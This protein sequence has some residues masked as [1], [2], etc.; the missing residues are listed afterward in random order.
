[1]KIVHTHLGGSVPPPLNDGS[2]DKVA[3]A[4]YLLAGDRVGSSH[5]NRLASKLLMRRTPSIDDFDIF[6]F[7]I[8]HDAFPPVRLS[9]TEDG[10]AR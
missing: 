7:N 10:S 3:G 6:T 4:T 9:I 8:L 2:R 1:M 5:A